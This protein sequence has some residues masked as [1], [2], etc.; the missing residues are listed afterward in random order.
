MP[1]QSMV[2]K[3]LIPVVSAGMLMF[4]LVSVLRAG[5]E[6][7]DLAP[8]APPPVSEFRSRVGAAAIVEPSSEYIGASAEV[9]GVVAELRVAAGGAVKKGDLLFRLEDRSRRAELAVREAG[10][11]SAR[12]RL[13]WAEARVASSSARHAKLAGGPRAE[14]LPPLEARVGAAR[15]RLDDAKIQLDTLS[16]VSDPRAI[17]EEDIRRRRV[18]VTEAESMLRA[19]EA[20][21]AVVK[22][23]AWERD[24][25]V[26]AAELA[27]AKSEALAASAE[28][29]SAEALVAQVK[30]ELERLVVRSPIDGTV[31]R[32]NVRVGE[33]APTERLAE[34]LVVLG[35]TTPLHVRAD[36]DE[37]DTWRVKPGAKAYA[38]LKGR[39][40]LRAPIEFVRFEPYVVPKRSLTGAVGERIDTRVLQAIYRLDPAALPVYAGQQV[41]VFIEAAPI[42][43]GTATPQ[44]AAGR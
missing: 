25:E 30:V 5:E 22:A 37:V 14:D 40:E 11:A 10:V 19:A 8:L 41:D 6:K 44:P 28:V 9:P 38:S 33:Y 18:A 26:A 17:R 7:P 29:A 32:V 31:L 1:K 35:T 27:A 42:S 13:T 43:G 3:L 20:D 12:A 15:S 34:P 24:I 16:R 21:F 4:T 23:G 2:S 39:A 36:I